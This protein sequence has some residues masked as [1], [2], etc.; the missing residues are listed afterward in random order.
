LIQNACVNT[1]DADS[2]H[3]DRS[4]E[5]LRGFFE[6]RGLTCQVFHARPGRGNLLVRVK[7]TDPSAKS[8][9][10]MG[11]LD[12]VPASAADWS[13]D[14]FAAEVKE[15][16]V[17]GRG[18]I[19]MLCWTAAQAVGF[20]EAVLA[21]GPKGFA[22]DL[23][24]LA[25]ADEEASGRWGAQHL[26]AHHWE[27]VKADFMVTELGGFFVPTVRGP[28]AF[29]NLGEKGVAWV[30]L[31][32]RG[33]PGHGSTPYRSDN[34]VLK[35]SEAAL[36]LARW[37]FP[38]RGSRVYRSM[39]RTAARTWLERCALILKPGQRWG[40][41]RVFARNQGL[42]RFLH[43]ASRTTASPNVV[44][45]GQKV[46]IVADRAE[47]LVDVRCVPG[48]TKQ[49]LL[50]ELRRALGRRLCSEVVLEI[51]DWFPANQSDA[52]TPLK[53]AI[54]SLFLEAHPDSQLAD[55]VIG[56]VTDGRFWREK[57]TTV[58]GFSLFSQQLTMDAFAARIH[59]I[60]ERLDLE[61]LSLGL[62]FFSELPLR[63]WR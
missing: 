5:V 51:T 47:L 52:R 53:V 40:L 33:T 20:A 14:P 55:M 19:D 27:S 62:A 56:G 59:G 32:A 2:G 3:E 8:L 7:G 23:A 36:R 37:K 21:A 24:F 9:M 11:H 38:F 17:W 22:G 29:C 12:V 42:A 46:N 63:F 1:G 25:L 35:V 26:V 48:T 44:R 57:G 16:Q 54:E 39:A 18:A 43:T 49:A 30:K 41:S 60:D 4:I 28:V 31:S 50:S 45:G 6:A 58:Y 61:S 13:V 34:A 15:N 10:F